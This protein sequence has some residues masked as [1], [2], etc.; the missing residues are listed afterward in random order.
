MA[1]VTLT[2]DPTA[3]LLQLARELP[4]KSRRVLRALSLRVMRRIKGDP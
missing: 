2:N 1:N 3:D 4:T